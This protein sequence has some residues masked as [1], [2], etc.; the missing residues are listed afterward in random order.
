MISL[1]L[2]NSQVFLSCELTGDVEYEIKYKCLKK[3]SVFS[4]RTLGEFVV[5]KTL[6]LVLHTEPKY[7]L[8]RTN[9]SL[10]ILS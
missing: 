1:N 7:L 5:W 3:G 6:M 4:S 2:G 10:N 8:Y 9:S